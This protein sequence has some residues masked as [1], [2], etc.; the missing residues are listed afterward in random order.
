MGG[1][2]ERISSKALADTTMEVKKAYHTPSA[3]RD[4]GQPVVS[5]SMNPKVRGPGRGWGLRA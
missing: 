1:K 2:R 3:G 5:F 4:P